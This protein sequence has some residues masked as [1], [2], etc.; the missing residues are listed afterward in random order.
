MKRGRL[1]VRPVRPFQVISREDA[2]RADA[3]LCMSE[4]VAEFSPD[5][6][7]TTCATC[8]RRVHHRPHVPK[9]PKKLCPDCAFSSDKEATGA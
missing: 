5:D 6:V 4:G 7:R 9:K 1:S 3:V 8:G 2:E